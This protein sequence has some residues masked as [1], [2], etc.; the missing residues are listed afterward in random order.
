M[1]KAA[2]TYWTDSRLA[3]QRPAARALTLVSP[4]GELSP[5][6]SAVAPRA[7]IAFG[8]RVETRRRG[9][10]VP[11]WVLFST[12]IL[13]TFGLCVTVTMRTHAE[14]RTA[15]QHYEAMSAEVEQLN[16]VNAAIRHDIERLRTDSGVEAAAR[17]RFRM[18]RADEFVVPVE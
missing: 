14:M 7:E 1:N 8:S 9:A 4:A 17:D 6:A 3:A 2:N 16:N 18:L 10:L 5:N 11:S 12:I 15:A 13:A